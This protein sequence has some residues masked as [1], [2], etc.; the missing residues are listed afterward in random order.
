MTLIRWQPARGASHLQTEMD[1]FLS[2]FLDPANGGSI[3]AARRWVPPMDV[4]ETEDQYL[5]RLDLPGTSEADISVELEDNVMTITGRRDS[6]HEKKAG[7]YYRV[8]RAT[9]AFSRSVT[10]PDGVEA[11]AVEAS[12]DRGVLEVRVPRPAARRPRKVAI[13]VG[14]APATIEAGDEAS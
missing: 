6:E 1:R 10:L 9:G 3:A 12:F 7:G 4:L 11:D 2:S 14:S 8:E 5:I 13:S